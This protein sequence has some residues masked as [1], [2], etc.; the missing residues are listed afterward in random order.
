MCA[1]CLQ[2]CLPFGLAASGAWHTFLLVSRRTPRCL[3]SV[4]RRGN[5]LGI[6]V[7]LAAHLCLGLFGSVCTYCTY[8]H[9]MKTCVRSCVQF[10]TG[11]TC[12]QI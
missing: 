11:S 12:G 6:V 1:S 2:F 5:G 10:L 8:C 4:A 9:S 3:K 7:D